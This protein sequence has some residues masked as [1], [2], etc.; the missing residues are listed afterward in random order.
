MLKLFQSFINIICLVP[1]TRFLIKAIYIYSLKKFRNILQDEEEIIDIFLISKLHDK[2]FIFGL[3]DMNFILLVKDTAR[4]KHILKEIRKSVRATWYLNFFINTHRLP[5]LKEREF[6][7]PLIRSFLVSDI[8]NKEHNWLSLYKNEMMTFKFSKQGRFATKYFLMRK[9]D[10]FMMNTKTTILN[11]NLLRSYGKYTSLAIK[12]MASEGLVKLNEHKYWQSLGM[13]IASLSPL[14][15]FKFNKHYTLTWKLLDQIQI[16]YTRVTSDSSMYPKPLLELCEKLMVQEGVEDILLTPA[17]LQIHDTQV[18]GKVFIDVILSERMHEFSFKKIKIIKKI[19]ENFDN[20]IE[21]QE[22]IKVKT[23]FKL[24]TLTLMQMQSQK[25]L[26]PYP[27]EVYYRQRRTFSV[28]GRKYQIKVSKNAIDRSI[29]HFTLLQ[30][31]RFRSQG[32]KNSLI[33]S[34]FIKSLNLLNRYIL[35]LEYLEKKDFI[36]PNN[37]AEM[38]AKITPQLSHM[39]HNDEVTQEQWPLIQAQLLY[40]LKKIRDLLSEDFPSIKKLTF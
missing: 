28:R 39:R 2:N 11:K 37:Y 24:S 12:S 35:I 4:P 29:I 6:S 25:S 14:A 18:R 21:T 22:E 32:L 17:L 15:R 36:V 34:R 23:S 40:T 5:I 27:L 33:G 38:L 19:I 16:P 26:F 8:D 13:S 1:Y 31:M 3:S 20:D 9:L 7:S 30:F 10:F